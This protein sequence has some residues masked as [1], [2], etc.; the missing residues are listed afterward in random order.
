MNNYNHTA[1]YLETF[2][3]ICRSNG[4]ELNGEPVDK[5]TLVDDD[6]REY[7]VDKTFNMFNSFK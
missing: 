2:K 7:E 4:I 1:E 3:E 6:G 5:F